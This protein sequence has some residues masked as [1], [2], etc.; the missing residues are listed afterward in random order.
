MVWLGTCWVWSALRHQKIWSRQLD[1]C[2]LPQLFYLHL[3]PPLHTA[4]SPGKSAYSKQVP[5]LLALGWVCSMGSNCRGSKEEKEWGRS[6]LT[7][8]F[9]AELLADCNPE[10]NAITLLRQPHPPSPFS[11]GSSSALA[12]L[13]ILCCL[14]WF[15]YVLST[16]S[17]CTNLR[18][19]FECYHSF[20]GSWLIHMLLL[21]H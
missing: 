12:C 11:L 1:T 19:Q 9:P 3:Q 18:V 17:N 15:S 21:I 7:W 5:L 10:S 6:L 8:F 14:Q 2:V 13:R 20:P 16:H 4:C